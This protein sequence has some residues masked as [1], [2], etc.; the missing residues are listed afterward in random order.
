MDRKALVEADGFVY[1]VPWA[2]GKPEPLHHKHLAAVASARAYVSAAAENELPDDDSTLV[3][4]F[5]A[6][7]GILTLI[8]V[9]KAGSCAWSADCAYN[10][11]EC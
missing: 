11:L 8:Y 3:L 5:T 1:S 2:R 4:S 9:N 6:A 7:R 10:A